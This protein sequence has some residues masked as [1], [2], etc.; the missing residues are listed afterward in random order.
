VF[1]IGLAALTKSAQ[2]P[3]S[4]WLPAAIAAPTPVSALVHSSTLV[5]AGVYLLIRFNELIG[6]SK[7]L[8][9]ISLLTILLSGLGACLEQ[10]AKKIVALSTLRQ[11]GVIIFSLSMGL[12]EIAFFHLLSHAL[13]K[14]L[15]FICIGLYIHGILNQQDLRGIGFQLYSIPVTSSYFLVSSL[16]LRGFPFLSGFYSKDSIIELF[17]SSFMGVLMYFVVTICVLRTVVYSIFLILN[18]YAAEISSRVLVLE[19]G[20]RLLSLVPILML[21]LV[22]V[23]GGSLLFN[24]IV[25]LFM[26]GF[27]FTL[28]VLVLFL[29]VSLLLL[30]III[31][32]LRSS[33]KI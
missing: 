7:L 10:D 14:S 5:T 17:Q 24:S 33:F 20:E 13:F 4:A 1:L 11:L 28:R 30:I 6:Y 12:W 19:V 18:L 15:L 29:V 25:P 27:M 16:S 23:L 26:V 31:F 32:L 22:S 9:F 3:F 2:V 8:F 21:Y